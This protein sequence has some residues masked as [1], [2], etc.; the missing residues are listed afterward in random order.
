[1]RFKMIGYLLLAL[2][3]HTS[4][5]AQIIVTDPDFPLAENAV[6]ITYNTAEGN[7]ALAGFTGDIYA[8][9]GVITN[10]SA[11]GSDWKYTIAGWREN[12]DKAKLIPIGN[13]LYK[14]NISPSIREFYGVPVGETILKMAFVFNDGAGGTR[15]GK[16]S[17]G[18][19]IFVDVYE[20]GLNVSFE[21]PISDALLVEL[22]DQIVIKANSTGA[23]SV[24]LYVND[25]WYTSVI[26]ED[27]LDATITVSQS[28]KSWVKTIAYANNAVDRI[29]D[30]FYYF[31][32]PTQVTEDLPAGILDGINYIND[33]TVIL[34]L[35]APYKSDVFAIGDF[36]DWELNEN[37]YMK[38][39][40]DGLRYWIQL[41]NLTAGQA[42]IY[43]YLIDG[44]DRFA[45]IYA[46]QVSDPWNDKWIEEETYPNL[47]EYPILKTTGVA[48][49]FTTG[50]TEYNWQVENFQ[51]PKITDLVIYETLVRDITDKHSYQSLIDTIG[52]FKNLGI[53]AIELM[54]VNEFEG[55]ESWGYNP[56]FYFAPDKY[57]GTKDDLK[58][59][60]DVCHQN[61]MAVI[62][63]MVLNH[64]YGSNP[65]V[66]MYWDNANDRPAA[67]NPWFNTVSPNTEYHWGYDFNHESK[68]TKAFVDRVNKYWI[69]NYKV[70]GFRFD[71]TKGFTN[72]SGNGW[73]YDA[74]RI[75]ILKRMA[76]K[77][78]ETDPE[79]Y[80]ILEHFAD[81]SEEKELANNGLMLWGNMNGS[82][83]EAHMG[84]TASGN[85]NID[86]ASYQKRGWNNPNLVVYMESHDEERQM[87][88][89]NTWGNN[90]GANYD[91]TE[92]SIGLE[93]MK[94]GFLFDFMIPGPK[95]LWQFE[96]LG[97]DISIDYNG[98]VGNKPPVWSYQFVT[99]N[100]SLHDFVA[101][102]SIL[103]TKLDVFET[104][105]FNLDVNN[106]LKRV[107][108]NSS[109]LNAVALG[110]FGVV[111]G[112]IVGSFPHAGTWYEYYSGSTLVVTDV[113]MTINLAAGAYKLYTDAVITDD[114][115][116][117][118]HSPIELSADFQ[119][120]P[121]PA[122]DQITIEVPKETKVLEWKI[123]SLQGKEV[124][125]GKLNN[126][127]SISILSLSSGI[128]ICQI[129]T[130]NGNY[131]KKLI[132]Q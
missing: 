8:H 32:R 35:Y 11:S 75:A 129:I 69:D 85:S 81:N 88:F 86:W 30:S 78:W 72:T 94:L 47:P 102:T 109:I 19:D 83:K 59:F 5:L 7:A 89:T 3:M 122:N 115:L 91:I 50:Q 108:L 40:P 44:E 123:F 131:R 111:S 67:N 63:D 55:N 45:D 2:L 51:K 16:T 96:E 58:E 118:I 48:S 66:H 60:I 132:K 93:R 120:F 53:N 82:F 124:L 52:Y 79:N 110:N 76:N 54:P 97:Y 49:V 104:T 15:E 61:G 26:T 114:Y 37:V 100:K 12:T 119:L 68:D 130:E 43:Q 17:T 41:N 121:N 116:T 31:V 38:K 9:T 112:N 70:D 4:I 84:Y 28:G 23:D 42:Y 128:Y 126:Q 21:L 95:M 80:V 24:A 125:A 105:D 62:I 73:A 57:Y 10:L 113:N 33:N 64:S 65:M 87:V 46:D 92:E 107:K 13:G 18:G 22:N 71:F 14:I 36:S 34:C 101:K 127:E 25:K 106:A 77:I 74:S 20:A 56:A 98:R 1:M 99:N 103:K 27:V 39:T 90:D 29:Q 6:V 117:G